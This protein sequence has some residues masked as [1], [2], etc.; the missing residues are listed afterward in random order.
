MGSGITMI[1]R[2]KITLMISDR[3]RQTVADGRLC[4]RGEARRLINAPRCS[5]KHATLSCTVAVDLH[6][7]CKQT[8][9][10]LKL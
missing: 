1:Y 6:L 4:V 5:G 10:L 8:A 3:G 2:T 7:R 9:H